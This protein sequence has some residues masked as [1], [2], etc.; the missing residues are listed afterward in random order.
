MSCLLFDLAIEPLA[1]AFRASTLRGITIPGEQERLIAKL[2]ADDTTVYLSEDDDYEEMELITTKWCRASRAKFNTSKTEVLPMGSRDYREKLIQTR[3]TNEASTR[4]PDSVHIVKE[5]E[6]IRSLG[7]WIGNNAPEATPWTAI[8]RTIECRLERWSQGHPTLNGRRL[9]VGME[10][11]GRT[12]FLAM[13]QGM[14]KAV[15]K[16]LMDM[17]VKFIWKGDKHPRVAREVLY[18]EVSE[19]GIKLL[20]ISARNEAI[21]LMWLKAYLDLTRDRPVWA[22]LA[23]ALLARAAAFTAKST[24]PEARINAFL[25]TWEVSTRKAA[26][27][28][29][30][31]RRMVTAAKSNA[32]KTVVRMPS[33]ALRKCMPAW[34]H[35]GTLEGRCVANTAA[36]KC[37]RE[38]HNVRTVD[39]HLRASRR[40][41]DELMNHK[42]TDSCLCGACQRDRSDL[43]CQH[44]N[45][46]AMTADR[47]IAKLSS[48]W[49]PAGAR[50]EDGLSLTRRRARL[51]D[52]ARTENGRIIF[53]PSLTQGTPLASVFRVFTPLRTSDGGA[54]RGRGQFQVVSEGVEVFTDGSCVDNGRSNARAG[55]GVW[56]GVDDIRNE[57][58]RVPH[59]AQS[60]QVAEMYAVTLAHLKTPPFAPLHIVSDSK[61]VVDGLTKHLPTW[62]QRGWIGVANAEVIKEA[63]ALL[64]TRSAQT[65]LRWVKGHANEL[66][67]EEADKLAK[68][69]ADAPRPF[70]PVALP[71][72]EMFVKEGAALAH[73]SQSL[74]Y[75]GVRERKKRVERKSTTKAV[76]ETLADVE[77]ATGDAHTAASLW[78]SLRKDPIE[79]KVRDFIWK[80]LHDAHRVGKFWLNIP[81]YEDRARCRYCE[82]VESLEHILTQC[83]APGQQTAWDLARR[84]LA[85]RKMKLPEMTLGLVTGC[86]LWNVKNDKNE[87]QTG[88][89]RLTRLIVSETAYLVWKLRCERVIEGAEGHPRVHTAEEIERRWLAG[90]NKRLDID[91]AL[92]NK[93]IAGRRAI[94]PHVVVA[95]W[96][97]VLQNEEHLPSDWTSKTGVLV[98]KLTPL[99]RRD[100]G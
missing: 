11:G 61:Y 75:R 59:D 57:G 70:R 48:K 22:A 95:T 49:Q 74:A 94:A 36:S 15:E 8:V 87:P 42:R 77:T 17:A 99:T 34:Y 58:V 71:P 31:L 23:D 67:N 92:T 27:L 33:E 96:G 91:C 26:G 81:G 62:E 64:R 88:L 76:Q 60:N 45:R 93:R 86:Q 39:D 44:P 2:F 28:P 35:P 97:G 100:E 47:A 1:A 41:H 63:V 54:L 5:G 7:A 43:D 21:D 78:I 37:L 14:P 9:I 85:K 20:D 79:R 25:Q 4:I 12:Q 40:L 51:N 10:F 90:V 65:T 56:F 83:R 6:A 19:G 18:S 46:C 29:E 24:A 50:N 16:T 82:C 89:S 69:G 38:K 72:K 80:A 84:L 13:A 66:G 98:G 73:L 55:S 32:V 3:R 52:T 68:F 53:D 30:D